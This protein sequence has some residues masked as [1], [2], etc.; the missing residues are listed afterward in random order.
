MHTDDASVPLHR[1]G[2]EVVR[3]H[4]SDLH[5]VIVVALAFVRGEQNTEDVCH[6]NAL[7]HS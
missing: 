5:A 3:T 7:K 2:P 4:H 1:H 6:Q